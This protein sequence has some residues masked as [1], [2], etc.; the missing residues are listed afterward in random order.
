MLRYAVI[1]VGINVNH[2]S[3]PAE[4]RTLATSL[5]SESGRPCARENA[6]DCVAAIAGGGDSHCS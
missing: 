1:G 2:Q 5:R 6:P 4:L 3:F